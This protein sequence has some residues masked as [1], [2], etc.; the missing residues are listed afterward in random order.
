MRR[1]PNG[2]HSTIVAISILFIYMT[3]SRLAQGQEARR[4]AVS[5]K[6]DV[7]QN[8]LR[9]YLGGP[10]QEED[11][12]TRISV[13]IVNLNLK[14][15]SEVIVYVTGK[16]WCGSGGCRTLVLARRDSSYRLVTSI[17]ISR[18]PI[19]VLTSSSNGWR[20]IGIWVQGG[21]I[22]PGYEAKLQFDG[23]SYPS[24]PSVPPAKPLTEKVA[25]QVIVPL[26]PEGTVLYP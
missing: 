21:G 19:R 9:S 4:T 10:T 5:T 26:E 11:K 15:P 20:D 13:A 25:G 14:G 12:T 17:T 18:P 24:N 22:Q 23:K 2:T 8:F 6:H 3:G 16:S 7:L 1:T